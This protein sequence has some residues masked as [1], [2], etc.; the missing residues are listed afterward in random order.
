MEENYELKILYRNNACSIDNWTGDDAAVTSLFND[1]NKD[2]AVWITYRTGHHFI[3]FSD[4]IE[5]IM[6]I[7]ADI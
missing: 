1:F 7:E 4:V 2:R 5:I 6:T 3:K